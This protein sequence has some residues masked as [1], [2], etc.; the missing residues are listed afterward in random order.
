[1][2]L[3]TTPT[4]RTGN[5]ILKTLIERGEKVRVLARK[6]ERISPDVAA[7]IEVSK[8]S[9]LEKSD[10][11]TALAG[12]ESLYFCIPESN[13]HDG[14][15]YYEN[16]AKIAADAIRESDVKR[17]VY[18]SGGGKNTKLNAGIA[19]GL[20]KAEDVLAESGAALRALRCPVFFESLLYQIEPITRAG[21]FFMP[22]SGDY[23]APQVAAQ[24]IADVAVKWLMDKSWNDTKGVGVHGAENISYN[25]IAAAMSL[26]M[27]KTIRF[28]QVTRHDYIKTLLGI[29]SSEA[30]ANALTDMFEA[31]PQ[32]LYEMEKRTS[33]TTTATSIHDWLEHSFLPKIKS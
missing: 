25:E 7:K 30:F 27:N 24:D 20:H 3:V 12:C 10:L 8:G 4:G 33:E 18:L 23:K 16:F 9:L 2:I 21:M 26:A 32:G 11:T 29:G 19:L 6:P 22:M 15:N 5:I 13:T 14:I 28:Q 17:I 1:M 31:I